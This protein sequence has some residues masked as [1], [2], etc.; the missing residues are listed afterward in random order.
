M[1]SIEV[2]FRA[3]AVTALFAGCAA[4]PNTTNPPP[5]AEPVA[6]EPPEVS[7][8]GALRLIMHQGEW[9]R[10]VDLAPMANQAGLYGLGA[11][12]GLD[13]EV[14]IW[15]GEL[16]VSRPDGSGGFE[17]TKNSSDDLGATLL[18]TSTVDGWSDIPIEGSLSWTE[19]DAFVE[20][21][22]SAAGLDTS[23]PFPFLLEVSPGRL[24]WHVIDGSRIPSDSHGH[25]A[26]VSTA[27]RGELSNRPVEI[28]GFFSKNH[29]GVFTHHISD[30]HLHVVDR[31]EEVTGHVDHLDIANVGLLRIPAS[32]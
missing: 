26:H 18:V 16:W 30:T 1:E 24:D 17:T 10:R 13:G 8:H 3:T 23:H 4:T 15:D 31:A 21:Q 9:Q 22:A 2:I 14:T 19:I 6:Q 29:R 28:L 7:I 27:V 25:E 5:I 12:E 11:I 20:A 32:R